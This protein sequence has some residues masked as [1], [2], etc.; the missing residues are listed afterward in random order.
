MLPED[1][2]GDLRLDLVHAFTHSNLYECLVDADKVI[3]EVPFVVGQNDIDQD[4]KLNIKQDDNKPI[5]QGMIDC[6]FIKDG[7]VSFIDYK[8]DAFIVRRGKTK[9]EVAETMMKKYEVQMQYY[10]K[11]L[12]TILQQPVEGYLYFFQYGTKHIKESN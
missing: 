10:K 12:E 6:I 2:I 3:R 7:K 4:V 5:I 9:E 1:A 8:T 11:T